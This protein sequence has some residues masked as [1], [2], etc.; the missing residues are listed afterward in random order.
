LEFQNETKLHSF[1]NKK[2]PVLSFVRKDVDGFKKL[3]TGLEFQNET[4]PHTVPHIKVLTTPPSV[5]VFVT[6]DVDGFKKPM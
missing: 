3:Y 2:S 6:K 5:L 4:V 1:H